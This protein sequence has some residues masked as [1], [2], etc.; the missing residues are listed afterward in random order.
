MVSDTGQQ[1]GEVDRLA[2]AKPAR[3]GAPAFIGHVA[4]DQRRVPVLLKRPDVHHGS[5][6]LAALVVRARPER[7]IPSLRRAGLPGSRAMV[8]VGPP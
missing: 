3:A 2:E 7:R 6:R 1:R 5:P 8:R 4:D